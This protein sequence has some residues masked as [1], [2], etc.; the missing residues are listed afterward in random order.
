MEMMLIVD[1]AFSVGLYVTKAVT[2]VL[3][4]E[5]KIV[6]CVCVQSTDIHAVNKLVYSMSMTLTIHE[7]GGCQTKTSENAPGSGEIMKK[8]GEMLLQIRIAM[9]LK[10]E[11][12]C[13][14]S[15]TEPG[16]QMP[17]SK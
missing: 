16:T 6:L 17:L 5:A 12:E 7:N 2:W 3:G 11:T 10:G 15:G 14:V 9:R 8:G 13:T 4:R 1:Y